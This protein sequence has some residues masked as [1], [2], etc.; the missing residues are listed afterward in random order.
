MLPGCVILGIMCK[1]WQV[2]L[3]FRLIF[4]T[5]V[6]ELAEN[7]RENQ[8]VQK[9]ILAIIKGMNNKTLKEKGKGF[10]VNLG[11]RIGVS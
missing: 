1:G 7:N 4:D 3:H 2:F 11:K 5:T 9:R 6:F 10:G 8:K